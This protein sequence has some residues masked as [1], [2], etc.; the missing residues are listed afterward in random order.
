MNFHQLTDKRVILLNIFS[1]ALNAVN[2][3]RVVANYLRQHPQ[4]SIP[5]RVIAIGKAAASMMQGVLDADAVQ[6]EAALVITKQGYAEDFS[7]SPVEITQIESAHPYADARTL[8]AGE[9]LLQFIQAAPNSIEFLFLISGGASSLVDVL[10]SGVEATQLQA[11]NVWLLAQGWPIE[12]MNQVRKSISRIKAGRLATLLD[13]HR[14]QQ[15]V[16]SDVPG[17]A[18]EVIGSGLL[19][20]SDDT[21]ALP[22]DLPDWVLQMQSK[23]EPPP[24]ADSACFANIQSTIVANNTQLRAAAS[25]AAQA[26]GY[27]VQFNAFIDGDAAIQGRNIARQLLDG[28]AGVYIWGGETV[29]TLPAHPGQ[30]GRCQHLALAAAQELAGAAQV[31]LLAIG[32]DGSDG[33][34]HVA[35]ALVDGQS[36][37]RGR[38]GGAATAQDALA[39]ADAGTFLAAS[40]DLVDTGP[41]GTNVMDLIIGMKT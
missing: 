38:D 19:V 29:V 35:G 7:A 8:A 40:G 9:Q 27:N 39:E 20:A 26:R 31:A 41:T 28:P 6:V 22:A 12:M 4:S 34:G 23:V 30:G 2:G 15:L 17:D 25:Q 32:S 3:R 16:I 33:P 5:V 18:L 14:V 36:I 10:P 11:F 13:G 1:E 21:A 37:A 24:A